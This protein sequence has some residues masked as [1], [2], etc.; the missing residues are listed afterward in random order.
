MEEKKEIV[1]VEADEVIDASTVSI[2]S[3]DAHV[4]NEL[5]RLKIEH[6]KIDA[7]IKHLRENT[8]QLKEKFNALKSSVGS[9]AVSLSLI[10]QVKDT[11]NN[12]VA[13]IRKLKKRKS[14]IQVTIDTLE[15]ASNI[16]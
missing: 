14:D 5:H 4:I 13:S 16:L 3:I 10:K 6:N 7:Q 9:D 15:K 12:T 8:E 2:S 11:Y 1:A